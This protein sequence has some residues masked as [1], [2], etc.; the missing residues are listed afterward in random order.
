MTQPTSLVADL[1]QLLDAD[2]RYEYEE[3]AGIIEF[4]GNVPR[5]DAEAFALIDLLRTHPDALLGVSM[6]EVTGKGDQTTLLLTTDL[7]GALARFDSVQA[8]AS[9]VT[10]LSETL[11]KRFGGTAALFQAF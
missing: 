6:V 2:L 8:K 1:V 3:R 10:N 9:R 5:Q 7:D 11:K 4:D